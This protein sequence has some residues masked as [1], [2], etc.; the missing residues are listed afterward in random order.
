MHQ[1]LKGLLAS[2]RRSIIHRDL[3]PENILVFKKKDQ[4][5][6]FKLADFNSSRKITVD[7]EY[8]PQVH[9][10]SKNYFSTVQF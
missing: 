2:H 5:D 4:P 6:V 9:R 1:L 8:S 7:G 3:K 10:V